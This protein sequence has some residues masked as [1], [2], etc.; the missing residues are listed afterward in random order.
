MPAKRHH[1]LLFHRR[2]APDVL[3]ITPPENVRH[4]FDPLDIDTLPLIL[5]GKVREY[6]I[7]A[8]APRLYSLLRT[9]S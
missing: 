4:R 8:S 9:F 5:S 2:V 3:P 6:G 1:K 7:R